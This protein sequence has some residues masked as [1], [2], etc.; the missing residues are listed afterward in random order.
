[1]SKEL[2]RLHNDRRLAIHG[3]DAPVIAGVSPWKTAARLL[4]EKKGMIEPEDPSEEERV[5]WGTILEDPVA[6]EYAR[7]HG[8]KVRRVNERRA[9]LAFGFPMVAQIDRLVTGTDTI[10]EIKTTSYSNRG[11]W[12]ESGTDEVPPHV[13]FQVLH[14][15]IVTGRKH[16]NVACLIGG[17]ELREYSLPYNTEYAMQLVTAE[18]HFWQLMQRDDIVLD[19]LSMDDAQILWR[20]P[21]SAPVFASGSN[22]HDAKRAMQITSEIKALEEEL[23]GC[24]GRLMSA[25]K[26]IGDEL[27]MGDEVL[28]TWKTQTST[29]LN[30]KAIRAALPDVCAPYLETSTSR[31]FRLKGEKHE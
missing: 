6:R 2:Y 9:T 14:Q 28:A 25:M 22:Y 24:K 21:A 13:Y 19:A 8:V 18:R 7:R 1:M 26:D 4:A 29:R 10:L 17:Q 31:V 16:A 30:A 23:K 11:A 5:L 15:M 27:V 12:G 20:H 3:S